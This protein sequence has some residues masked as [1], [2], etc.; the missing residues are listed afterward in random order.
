M[1]HLSRISEDK[2]A[3]TPRQLMAI[4]G[5]AVVIFTTIH[6]QDFPDDEGDKLLGRKT[7]TLAYPEFARIAMPFMLIFWSLV[8]I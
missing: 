2:D 6:A 4:I 1:S 5:S 7:L 8:F 3:L